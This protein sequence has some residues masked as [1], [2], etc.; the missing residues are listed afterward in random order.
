MQD[1]E[2][3]KRHSQRLAELCASQGSLAAAEEFYF[4]AGE[5]AKSVAMWAAAR[6][7]A[8]AY[9]AS[10]RAEMSAEKLQVACVRH[11]RH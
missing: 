3:A 1:P 5:G 2:A 11:H 4:D 10:V 7:W 8:D 9:S 6:F